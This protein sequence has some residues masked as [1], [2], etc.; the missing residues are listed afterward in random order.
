MM[1][2]KIVIKK[3]PHLRTGK[4]LVRNDILFFS[5]LF[6]QPAGEGVWGRGTRRAHSYKS[7]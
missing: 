2:S 6:L 7:V 3:A 5:W 4:M 1:T